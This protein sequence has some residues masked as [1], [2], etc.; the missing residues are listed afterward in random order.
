MDR[1]EGTA[2]KDGGRP[3]DGSEQSQ[4]GLKLPDENIQDLE[5]DG[6]ES[7]EVTGGGK[8]SNIVL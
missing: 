4:D 6:A 1:R 3:Q 5:P 7:A 8:Y 2:D